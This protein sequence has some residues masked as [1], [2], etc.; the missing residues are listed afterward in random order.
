MNAG[1]IACGYSDDCLTGLHETGPKITAVKKNQKQKRYK[2]EQKLFYCPFLK[3]VRDQRNEKNTTPF[4][5]KTW[6][7]G[8]KNVI[9]KGREKKKGTRISFVITT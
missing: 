6:K 4:Y 5:V 8:D 3:L 1:F 7:E 9:L 2:T